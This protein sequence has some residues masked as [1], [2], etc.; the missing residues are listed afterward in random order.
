MELPH[1]SL[2]TFVAIG[3]VIATPWL[4]R[5]YT[6]F[7]NEP[8]TKT[9]TEKLVSTAILGHTLYMLY[10]LFVSPP[11]NIF[12]TLDLPLNAS[13]EALRVKLAESF[14]GEQNVPQYLE[15]LMKRLGLSDLRALYVRFGHEVLTTCS[16]CQSFDDYALYAF[17]APLLEYIR[18]IAFVGIMTLPKSR[19]AYLRPLGLGALLASL[20]TEAYW[21]LTVP[22]NISSRGS[23]V[24]VIMWHDVFVQLRHALF[25]V[26]PLLITILPSLNLHSI[27]ILGAF[28]PAPET[29]ANPNLPPSR[30]QLQGQQTLI[31]PNATL[32]HVSNLTLKTLGHLMPTLHLLKYSHAS[33]MRSQSPSSSAESGEDGNLHAQASEWW[34]EEAREGSIVRSDEDVRKVLK[35]S[36]LSMDEE[37]KDGDAVVQP[38]GQLLTSAK[39]AVSMLQEQGAPP[40]EHWIFQ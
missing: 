18:E 32:S 31:P 6:P 27:P 7:S 1:L 36:G 26:L 9:R 35:A 15:L 4:Y 28:M 10:N 40:S 37:V 14:G 30:F 11:Q 17:P 12:K 21:I 25:L 16:Y 38:E 13:P 8:S 2:D 29:T 20:M 24:P 22:V 33:I 34:R 5:I 3:L 19:T 23:E 39:M